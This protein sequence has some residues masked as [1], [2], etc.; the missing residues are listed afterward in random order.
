MSDSLSNFFSHLKN[1]QN[2]RIL[3]IEHPK[4][5]IIIS[6]LEILQE[7]GYIRGYRLNN[8]TQLI[9]EGHYSKKT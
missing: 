1:A 8:S 7:S 9:S 3:V 2:N 4:S 6:I 5:K